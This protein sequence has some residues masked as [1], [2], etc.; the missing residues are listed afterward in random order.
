VRS[1]LAGNKRL[2][3]AI[4][5]FTARLAEQFAAIEQA[6]ADRNFAELAALGHWLKG[7]AGTVG[8]DEFTEPAA[9]FEQA[10]KDQSVADL[11]TMLATLRD[12]VSRLEAPE[13]EAAIAA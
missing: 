11:E 7:A 9:L 2:R 12:L 3:P 6:Y 13:E 1:R 4:R 10:A 8:Y 5:K